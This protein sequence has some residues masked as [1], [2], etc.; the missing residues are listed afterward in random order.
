M[1]ETTFTFAEV[2]AIFDAEGDGEGR[3]FKPQSWGDDRYL[4]RG[5][6]GITLSKT[7]NEVSVYTPTDAE[8]AET[9]VEV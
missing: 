5:G 6:V 3:K 7:G 2:T 8:Q 1:S 9:W 4:Y